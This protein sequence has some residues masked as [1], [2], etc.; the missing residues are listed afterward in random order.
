M[1]SLKELTDIGG[2]CDDICGGV[3]IVTFGLGVEVLMEIGQTKLVSRE[4]FKLEIPFFNDCFQV[5][6]A[7][8]HAYLSCVWRHVHL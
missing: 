3:V 8:D 5:G 1:W 2:Y 7:L 4:G 6:Y